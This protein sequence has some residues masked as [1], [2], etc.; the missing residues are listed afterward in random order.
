M[1]SKYLTGSKFSLL[2]VL[3]NITKSKAGTHLFLTL[4]SLQNKEQ[5]DAV[6]A[7]SFKLCIKL[8]NPF[9][10]MICSSTL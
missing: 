1:Q 2:E 10:I 8:I 7:A 3:P 9:K 6:S 4:N 5:R